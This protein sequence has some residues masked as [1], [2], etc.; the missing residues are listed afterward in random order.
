MR[1]AVC[2]SAAALA[3]CA[4]SFAAKY[5]FAAEPGAAYAINGTGGLRLDAPAQRG[6]GLRLRA[7]LTPGR[8]RTQQPALLAGSRFALSATFGPERPGICYSDT[9]FRDDFDADGF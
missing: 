6:G 9:I 4:G 5:T 1:I 3:L 2:L 8:P 7:T